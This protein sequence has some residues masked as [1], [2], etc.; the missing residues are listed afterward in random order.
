MIEHTLKLLEFERVRAAVAGFCAGDQSRRLLAES[1]F[2]FT[3]ADV[4]RELGRAAS[5]HKL[6]ADGLAFPDLDLPDTAE[7]LKVARKEGTVLDGEA[8]VA[9]A[10][11]IHSAAALKRFFA[12]QGIAADLRELAA[13]MPVPSALAAEIFRIFDRE[14]NVQYKNVP[15]LQKIQENIRRLRAQIEKTAAGF[16]NNPDMAGLFQTDT[17]TIKEGRTVLPLKTKHKGRLKG[18]VHEVSGR[19]STLFLEPEE[20]VE[21]NN[22]LVVQENLFQSELLRIRRE[23]TG[24]VRGHREDLERMAAVASYCDALL[25]KARYAHALRAIAALP[26]KN[27]IVLR[28][29]RHPLLGPGVVPIDLL[30]EP[31]EHVLLITGPNTGGKT[32]TLKTAGLFAC[33][34]QF[35]LEVPAAEGTALPVFDGV[36]ADIGDEQSLEQSLSTYQ[37]HMNNMAAIVKRATGSSLVLLDELGAGTDPQEGTAIAMALLDHFV[38]HQTKTLATTHHGVLKNY[39][40]IKKG[41]VNASVEFDAARLRPTYRLIMGVPGESHALSIAQRAGLPDGITAKAQTYLDEERTDIGRLVDELVREKKTLLERGRVQKVKEEE[42][43]DTLRRVELKDLALR[44]KERE[45][46]EKGIGA[47]EQFLSE[48]R[49]ALERIIREIREG[50]REEAVAGGRALI[51][52][53]EERIRIESDAVEAIKRTL[54]REETGVLDEGSSVRVRASGSEGTVLRRLKDDLFVVAV[55]SVRL[56]LSAAEL[57][58]LSDE[59]AAPKVTVSY[60]PIANA[61]VPAFELNVRGFR[62]ADALRALEKQM[63][64]VLVTGV[65][66]FTILHGK[67]TGALRTGIHEYLA[68]CPHVAAFR[69][70]LPEHGGAG[71]TIVEMK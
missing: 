43:V 38:A 4:A 26:S 45:L 60:T 57:E 1:P 13:G 17:A 61:P 16:L 3:P 29:A 64:A 18:I 59:E 31:D 63:D 70:A 62:Y 66:E 10:R 11:F 54:P 32:V 42:A 8:L 46:R 71:K 48:S 22:E 6:F 5:L 30:L 34:N 37:A 47:L 50:S 28:T 56:T 35:G 33:M 68:A 25:A 69:F 58:A 2:L 41:V 40:F 23:L 14:G 36:Y 55:G 19:G 15:V 39:G 12:G 51:E 52:R 20:I 7:A 65:R 44:Q 27:E 21:K 53:M 24:S 67:G 49:R 9:V